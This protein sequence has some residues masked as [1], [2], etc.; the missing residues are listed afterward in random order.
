MRGFLSVSEA[1]VMCRCFAGMMG[2]PAGV[3]LVLV[4]ELFDGSRWVPRH[5]SPFQ[6]AQ[7]TSQHF[8]LTSHTENTLRG[9]LFLTLSSKVEQGRVFTLAPVVEILTSQHTLGA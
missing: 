5:R 9:E 1:T 8:A 2:S 7:L 3:V 6:S 4:S